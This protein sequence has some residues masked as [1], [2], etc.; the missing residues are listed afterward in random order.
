MHKNVDLISA[1]MYFRICMCL[2]MIPKAL[3]SLPSLL[4]LLY[5]MMMYTAETTNA[6]IFPF[7]KSFVRS[8]KFKSVDSHTQRKRTQF[9][10][11]YGYILS[12]CIYHFGLLHHFAH[13]WKCCSQST[14]VRTNEHILY[15]HSHSQ[16]HTVLNF[17]VGILGP[18]NK[19]TN[20]ILLCVLT[21]SL[22]GWMSFLYY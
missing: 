4:A 21:L 1:T 6:P 14:T 9:L 18:H 10:N 7:I 8:D 5:M 12:L 22:F 20:D 16:Y 19:I 2:M 15:R 11:N 13:H 17:R 3:S